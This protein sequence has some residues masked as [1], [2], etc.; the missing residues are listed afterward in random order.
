[1]VF[2]TLPETS[3]T[4]PCI[5]DMITFHSDIADLTYTISYPATQLLFNVDYNQAIPGC[6]VTCN[7]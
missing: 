6:G 1:V 2:K 3:G 7:L 5:N 4:N